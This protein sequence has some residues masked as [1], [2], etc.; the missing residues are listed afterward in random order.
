MERVDFCQPWHYWYLGSHNSARP[1]KDVQQQPW[2]LEAS[3]PPT[4]PS[5]PYASRHCWMFPWESW[6]LIWAHDGGSDPPRSALQAIPKADITHRHGPVPL[7]AD[8]DSLPHAHQTATMDLFLWIFV[9]ILT[10]PP[11]SMPQFATRQCF[12]YHLPPSK[13]S[14]VLL[15][16]FSWIHNYLGHPCLT[17]HWFTYNNLSIC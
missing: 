5:M 14:C 6:E 16:F 2:P 10:C 12:R 4:T 11:L 17:S 1:C 13:V 3:S 7:S 9:P 8:P 15:L